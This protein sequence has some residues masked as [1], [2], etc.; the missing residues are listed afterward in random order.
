ML[1]IEMAPTS[2][3]REIH[4]PLTK[5]LGCKVPIL[6]APMSTGAGGVLAGKV[7]SYGGFSFIPAGASIIFA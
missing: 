2:T 3:I 7:T 1:Q 4:T 5:L 6:L